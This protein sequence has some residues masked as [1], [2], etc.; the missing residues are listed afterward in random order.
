MI[1]RIVTPSAIGA[2]TT[3]ERERRIRLEAALIARARLEIQAGQGIDD[4]ALDAWLDR[5]DH[6]ENA[7]VP[8]RHTAG[9]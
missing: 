3:A 8:V 2:E 9:G 5:L 4:D 7:P 1:T 6:D